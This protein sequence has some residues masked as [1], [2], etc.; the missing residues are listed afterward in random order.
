MLIS[1]STKMFDPIPPDLLSVLHSSHI[2][3]HGKFEE[4]REKVSS[5]LFPRDSVALADSLVK[6]QILTEYQAQRLLKNKPNG[7]I[8]GRYLILERI[9]SG[10]MARVYKA[11]HLLM[12]RIVA[13]KLIAPE[14]IA[15][16]RKRARFQREIRLIG[17]LDHPNI[18]RAFDADQVSNVPFIAMEYVAGETL[19]ERLKRKGPLRPIDVINYSAQTAR[20]MAHAHEQGV[21][22]RDLKPSNLFLKDDREIKILDF[23]LSILMEPDSQDSFATND[24]IA[25]GTIDYMSPEQTCGND[26]DGRSDLYSLGCVMYHLMTQRLLFPGSSTIERMANRIKGHPV[27]IGKLHPDLPKNLVDVME[28]LLAPRP[29]HRYQ[30]ATEAAEALEGLAGRLQGPDTIP[31]TKALPEHKSHGT[32]GDM[33]T[34]GAHAPAVSAPT[35]TA[36][37]P[38]PSSLPPL[39]RILL[40]LAEQSVV[41]IALGSLAVLS[42]AFLAG[43]ILAKVR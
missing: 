25:V 36:P 15:S 32:N 41:K 24:G 20:G 27:A 23:G 18:V 6:A 13:L 22:H 29:E 19:S 38:S 31:A 3:S 35:P 34:V 10:S 16:P 26:I 40:F 9:G 21:V 42:F 8:I 7:F 30:T 5:G 39:F 14:Y 37:A 4:V 12:D 2:L 33:K 1:N 11:R 43:F 28:K 17:R